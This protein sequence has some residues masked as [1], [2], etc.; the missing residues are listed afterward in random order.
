ML[1]FYVKLTEKKDFCPFFLWISF[2]VFLFEQRIVL[3]TQ[4]LEG[5]QGKKNCLTQNLGTFRKLIKK[6]VV[7]SMRSLRKMSF[8]GF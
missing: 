1:K 8:P 5:Q 2:I 3:C 6:M 7:S 4:F